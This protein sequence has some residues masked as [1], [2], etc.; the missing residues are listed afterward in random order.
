MPEFTREQLIEGAAQHHDVNPE[1]AVVAED[2][3]ED[4]DRIWILDAGGDGYHL[5]PFGLDEHG[6]PASEQA[7]F[8][9]EGATPDIQ[10]LLK[11]ACLH[12]S[13]QRLEGVTAGEAQDLK[14]LGATFGLVTLG[15]WGDADA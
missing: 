1:Q 8:I 9:P 10:N 12:H 6:Q 15:N 11:V 14:E 7:I 3:T 13:E 2:P 5:I 4:S